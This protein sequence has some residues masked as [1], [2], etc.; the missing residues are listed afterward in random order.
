[1]SMI[2][3]ADT[4]APEIICPR[5]ISFNSTEVD[6]QAALE[7][8]VISARSTDM[9]MPALASTDFDPLL[10]D[11]CLADEIV[12]VTFTATDGCN[13]TSTC[14]SDINVNIAQPEI[15]CPVNDLFLQCGDPDND[16]TIENW[17][18]IATGVDNN[19]NALTVSSDFNENSI[20]GDCSISSVVTFSVI[21]TC[22][23]LNSCLLYTSPSPRDR[24]RSR[25]PSSA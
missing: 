15:T 12:T 23:Q 20:V 1:M 17:L 6:Y 7:S 2:R 3:L 16:V 13:N 18:S 10:F 4:I 25:M 21:D 5:P 14:T 24:T 9:C 22:G 11:L 8:W 19:L